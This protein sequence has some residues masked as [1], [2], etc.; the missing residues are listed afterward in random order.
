[1]KDKV[2]IR[3]QTG[4]GIQQFQTIGGEAPSFMDLA[5]RFRDPN[6]GRMERLRAGVGLGGK[7]AA[8]LGTVFQTAHQL[9]G[10]NALAPLGMGYTYQGLDPTAGMRNSVS[11]EQQVADKVRQMQINQQAKEQFEAMRQPQQEA[12]P[13]TSTTDFPNQSPTIQQLSQLDPMMQVQPQTQQSQ[14]NVV[15]QAAGALQ[16][17]PL[18]GGQAPQTTDAAR[19]L[20]G[21]G[22]GMQETG[23]A[24]SQQPMATPT[25]QGFEQSTLQQNYAPQP[26]QNPGLAPHQVP[27]SNPNFVP[28]QQVVPQGQPYA[29][30]PMSMIDPTT[31]RPRNQREYFEFLR[32]QQNKSFATYVLNEFGDMLHK[33]DPHVAGLLAFR[34][35]MDKMMR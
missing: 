5:R 25:G 16:G 14:G 4:G 9:Q 1:L 35:Y 33:A 7:V 21:F 24:Q 3:K 8:G 30:T 34:V 15:E 6:A 2:L 19:T 27:P 29:G 23:P 20:A 10:G 13:S 11:Q 18:Q 22:V 17:M 28:Q 26:P 12:A 32:E 31:G